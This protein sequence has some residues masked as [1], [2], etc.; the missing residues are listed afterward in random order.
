MSEHEQNKYINQLRRQLVNVMERIKTLELD[1]EPDGRISEAFSVMEKH[2]DA[3][4]D[5]FDIRF[6]H[7]ESRLDRMDHQF[8]QLQAKLTIILDAITGI[9]DLPEECNSLI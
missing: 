4:F 1:I 2:M 5:Q 9:G 3:R 8:N 7:L 6:D